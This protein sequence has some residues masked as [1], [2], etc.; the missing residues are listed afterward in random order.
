MVDHDS[1]EI[2]QRLADL[3]RSAKEQ[4]GVP[5]MLASRSG[6]LAVVPT[7]RELLPSPSKKRLPW[8][9]AAQ[10]RPE[11]LGERP[12]LPPNLKA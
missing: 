6:S 4:M 3:V 5:E 11:D 2:Q 7:V 9:Q 8:R 10:L 12:P 1:P